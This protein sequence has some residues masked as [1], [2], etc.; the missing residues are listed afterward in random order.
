MGD[1]KVQREDMKSQHQRAIPVIDRNVTAIT[2][3][4]LSRLLM[5]P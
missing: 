4:R 5:M 3:P 1:L 2:D